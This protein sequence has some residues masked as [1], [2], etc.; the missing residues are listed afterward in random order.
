MRSESTTKLMIIPKN[1]EF[2]ELINDS[3]AF[4]LGIENM[5]INMPIYFNIDEIGLISEKLYKKKKK[6]FIS[7]NKNMHNKDLKE[8]ERILTILNDLKIE[9]VFYYDV[10]ILSIVRRLKLDLKLVWS[11]EHLTTNYATINF[12]KDMKIDY[13][14]LS[15]EITL[16][17]IIE[18]SKINCTNLWLSSNLCIYETY[19]KKLFKQI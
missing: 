15:A 10:A 8:L 2:D 14:Y 4:L 17:E 19:C 6:L 16:D 5:S 7:L 1:K 13:T 3:D 12:W 18:I 9:G 11:S